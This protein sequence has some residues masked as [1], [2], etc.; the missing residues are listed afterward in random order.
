M[1]AKTLHSL[2]CIFRCSSLQQELKCLC[3][4]CSWKLVWKNW[5]GHMFKVITMQLTWTCLIAPCSRLL[6]NFLHQKIGSDWVQLNFDV[7]P[8][9]RSIRKK[10]L[11]YNNGVTKIKQRHVSK[12]GSQRMDSTM[13]IYNLN[14]RCLKKTLTLKKYLD[15]IKTNT[16]DIIRWHYCFDFKSKRIY[17][18]LSWSR[19]CLSYRPPHLKQNHWN[20]SREFKILQQMNSQ[21]LLSTSAY[22]N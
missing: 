10:F 8:Q 19:W 13:V 1:H 15:I 21:Y 6:F 2:C 3:L 17:T 7:Q 14:L 16:D 12:L 9:E 22:Q 5:R 4:Q 20:N 18:P 11:P